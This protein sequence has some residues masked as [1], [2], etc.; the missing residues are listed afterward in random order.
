MTRVDEFDNF[1]SSTF[2]EVVQVTYA[3]CGDRQVAYEATVDAYRRAWRDWSKIRDRDPISYVR[4][5]AW[6]LTALSRGTHPLRK[7]NE[8]DS[9]TA[10]LTAL[11]NLAVDDRRLIVLMTLG[12]TDL[13][14]ASR[15]VGLPAEEG[16]ENVTTAL[17]ALE[18]A[19]GE[20]IDAIER[21][22]HGLSAAT[23][24]LSVPSATDVRSAARRGRRRNTILLVAAALALIVGGG[25]VATDGDAL[26][27]SGELPTRQKFG[28]ETPVKLDAREVSADNLLSAKQV[29]ALDPARTW[30]VESTDEDVKNTTPYATCPTKRFADPDPEKVFVRTFTAAGATTERVAQAIEVSSSEKVATASYRRLVQWYADCEHPRVELV[31]AYTVKRPFGDFQ[32]LKLRSHREPQRT[33]TVGFSHSGTITSTLVHEVD[34][35]KGPSIE[36]FARTLNDSVAKVC[37]DSGGE[38]SQSIQVMRTDPPATSEAPSFLGIVDLPPIADIDKVWAAAR[39]DPRNNPA[40]TLCDKADFTRKG[41]RAADSRIYVLYQADNLPKEFGVAETVAQFRSGGQAKAFVRTVEKRIRSCDDKILSART[42]Q[43]AVINNPAFSGRAWRVSFEISDK[44]K[45]RVYY[46]TAIIRRG[47]YVAQVTFTPAGAYDITKR[48]FIQIATRAGTRLKYAE[49][50]QTTPTP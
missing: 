37:K 4:T 13:E 26:A 6:K 25:F 49:P 35:V 8:D 30:K 16:I 22:M 43:D 20:G 9:D 39:V 47:K 14:E 1:Y 31:A 23:E 45:K 32:I 2:A 21:R 15:E 28:D 19:L 42:K 10:L 33:F 27:T 5:E 17:A 34:G 29:S 18:E 36:T 11:H 48:E 12:N 40:A 3:V 41:V 7:R 44:S 50:T 24:S 46:R 38:C